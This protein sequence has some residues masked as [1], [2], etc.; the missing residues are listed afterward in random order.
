M[1]TAGLDQEIEFSIIES[2]TTPSGVVTYTIRHE[3]DL[4]TSCEASSMEEL[5]RESGRLTAGV[6]N[7]IQYKLFQSQLNVLLTN[8]E[9]SAPA[10]DNQ[11][12]LRT[13]PSGRTA[14]VAV[15]CLEK[16]LGEISSS[17]PSDKWADLA[18]YVS[19]YELALT[20]ANL[21][22]CGH[23]SRSIRFEIVYLLYAHPNPEL[24]KPLLTEAIHT[25][26]NSIGKLSKL[27]RNEKDSEIVE[28]IKTRCT[29]FD[30]LT[31]PKSPTLSAKDFS[32]LSDLMEEISVKVQSVG[33]L[34]GQVVAKQ[35]D[36]LKTVGETIHIC[37]DHIRIRKPVLQEIKQM[38]EGIHPWTGRKE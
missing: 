26:R 30:L 13:Q 33:S 12:G 2:G 4:E 15:K 20:H 7:V 9:I 32:A 25:V 37:S 6:T 14:A 19:Q 18:R 23:L 22:E 10:R 8:P 38:A 16:R 28:N 1:N 36:M 27:V 5:F 21:I 29:E 17:Y 34:Q 35:N 3:L 31:H 11:T 24:G